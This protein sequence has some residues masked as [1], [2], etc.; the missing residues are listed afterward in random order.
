MCGYVDPLQ[1]RRVEVS[2]TVGGPLFYDG[3]HGVSPPTPKMD[4]DFLLRAHD[5]SGQDKK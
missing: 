4:S 2:V 3:H 1:L 5:R